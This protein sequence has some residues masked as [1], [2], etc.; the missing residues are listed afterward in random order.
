L[1]TQDTN[2]D[3]LTKNESAGVKRASSLSVV[4]QVDSINKNIMSVFGGQDKKIEIDDSVKNKTQEKILKETKLI[5]EYLKDI[6][7]NQIDEQDTSYKGSRSS[8]VGSV[9][10][11][12]T[13]SEKDK[14]ELQADS[15]IDDV[16]KTIGAV[17]A[18]KS[19]ARLVKPSLAKFIPTKLVGAEIAKTSSKAVV[20]AVPKAGKLATLATI[21]KALAQ[22]LKKSSATFLAKKIP[23]LGL[24]IGGVAAAASLAAGDKVG[25]AGYLA[26]GAASTIPGI[27]TGV[28]VVMDIA[29]ITRDV[30]KLVYGI[31]PE[32]DK[33]RSIR[34]GGIQD[35]ITAH[36]KSSTSVDK[37]ASKRNK[38]TSQQKLKE[39]APKAPNTNQP[40]K[41]K[42]PK[43]ALNK[44]SPNT[45]GPS[46]IQEPSPKKEMG[47][48]GKISESFTSIASSVGDTFSGAWAGI[49]DVVLGNKEAQAREAR[50]VQNLRL[51]GIVDPKTI[52]NITGQVAV[53]TGFK[54]M[55]EKGNGVDKATGIDPYFN[56][57]EGSKSLGNTQPGDGQKY[58]GRGF[59]QI[60]GRANYAAIG[61][62]IGVDLINNP[63]LLATNEEISTRATLA[64]LNTHID[65][66][67]KKSAMQLAKE[68]NTVALGQTI[69]AGHS[70]ANVRYN[71]ANERMAQ[72]Q[73]RMAKYTNNGG[74]PDMPVNNDTLAGVSAQSGRVSQYLRPA[75]SGV[76]FSGIQPNVMGNLSAMADD[77]FKRFGKT[78][79]IN[80]GYRSSAQQQPL[81]DAAVAKYG[82]EMASKYA[83]KPGRSPHNMG[84]AFDVNSSDGNFLEKSGLLKA[85]GFTRPLGN[86]KWHVEPILNNRLQMANEINNVK[87][88]TAP[89]GINTAGLTPPTSSSSSDVSKAKKENDSP[90]EK[91]ANVKASVSKT[92]KESLVKNSSKNI[93]EG[94]KTKDT[95][96][97]NAANNQA[98]KSQSV[99]INNIN[100][101]NK[102]TEKLPAKSLFRDKIL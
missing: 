1:T 75:D 65:P 39:L 8:G 33:D 50:F 14:K 48:F 5:S 47:F 60:T 3:V 98:G 45:I 7:D 73:S 27:G 63:D 68:G 78:L 54:R 95:S 29:L 99:S 81:W 71:H 69:N 62:K 32:D 80:S 10:S 19:L 40:P 17:A 34:I 21:K 9:K 57:Y 100:N 94:T 11:S 18:I 20:G 15:M 23:I 13:P 79:Q 38:K 52:A 93:I 85:Y 28:S 88:V 51:N 82:P 77:Y 64:W 25:A 72:T 37:D 84:M 43:D 49:K 87:L 89:K 102:P 66:T 76:N 74:M 101:N 35:T 22:V 6:R 58:K 97:A 46:N 36:F 53:E 55:T 83:A 59:I 92:P 24:V 31:W 90:K 41:P 96:T 44:T 86:E 42:S 16:L 61:K 56:R 4:N 26:S 91:I 30:Y 67:T 12:E 70:G 2:P